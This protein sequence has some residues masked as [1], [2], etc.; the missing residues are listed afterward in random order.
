MNWLEQLLCLC[1]PNH[2][3]DLGTHFAVFRLSRQFLR[4]QRPKHFTKSN[5]FCHQCQQTMR[6][7]LKCI[8]FGSYQ[9]FWVLCIGV[10][11]D[12]QSQAWLEPKLGSVTPRQYFWLAIESQQ[13]YSA[14]LSL[15]AVSAVLEPGVPGSHTLGVV[16]STSSSIV[17]TNLCFFSSRSVW[18]WQHPIVIVGLLS[19]WSGWR[20]RNIEDHHML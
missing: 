5:S 9:I 12:I 13:L 1:V 3:P 17:Q 10:I 18:L 16:C 8:N 19:L 7:K 14:F 2:P 20:K 6:W 4:K 15:S 11:L